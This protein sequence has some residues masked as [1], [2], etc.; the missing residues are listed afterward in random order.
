VRF[1]QTTYVSVKRI[2]GIAWHG[3]CD[4][5]TEAGRSDERLRRIALTAMTSALARILGAAV[6]LVTLGL[7]I[8]YLGRETYGLWMTISAFLSLFV[9]ADFGLG[10]GLLTTLSRAHG[11]GDME[12]CRRLLSSAFFLLLFVACAIFVAFVALYPIVPWSVL[13]NANSEGATRLSAILAAAVF[14]PR[15]IQ[16][17]F[18][19][20]QRAQLAFQEGY[21]TDLWQCGASVA[22]IAVV[23]IIAR[24]DFGQVTLVLSVALV[25]AIAFVLN[26]CWFFLLQRRLLRPCW[27]NLSRTVSMYLM[28]TGGAYCVL[29]VL[30]TAGLAVDNLI[31]A[32]MCGLE[33]VATFSIVSRVASLL[34]M[35]L[36]MICMPMWSAN[37][38][39]LARGDVAWVRRMTLRTV[40][41]TTWV[42]LIGGVVM[43]LIGPWVFEVWL[44]ESFTV[45]RVMLTGFAG[46]ELAL[47]IASPF[48]MVL[49]GAGRVWVQIRIVSVYTSVSII[50]KVVM[51]HMCGS[52]GVPWAMV[53]SYG[54]LVLPFVYRAAT[55]VCTI[56]TIE[57]IS[58]DPAATDA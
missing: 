16:L 25:P 51:A 30:T 3:P 41:L 29:S 47:S 1:I 38:E 6:P 36:A 45:S 10:S 37:G 56:D 14:L 23:F 17:P 57:R 22:S 12:E 20:V 13:L 54:L 21:W 2:L 48:F 52:A 49:N 42:A 53:F 44:G 5:S 35:G 18:S 40:V 39:A 11:L 19:M 28:Q 33:E 27:G 15:V 34:T 31:V 9:F 58:G 43:V 24:C 55:G 4:Q 8:E 7:S 26:W 50:L 46:R 32:H